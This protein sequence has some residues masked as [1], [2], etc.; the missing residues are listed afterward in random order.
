[1]VDVILSGYF[2]DVSEYRLDAI[3]F[4]E[5]AS[6]QFPELTTLLHSLK[7]RGL[8]WRE[9]ASSWFSTLF[10]AHLPP[11][12]VARVW[13]ILFME[14]PVILFRIGLALISLHREKLVALCFT[15]QL[16]REM[17]HAAG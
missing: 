3:A 7:P 15:S 1:M 2:C 14:G 13:D 11:T 9:V 5:L 16:Q 12:M 8:L 4:E 6:K 17:Q 10:A